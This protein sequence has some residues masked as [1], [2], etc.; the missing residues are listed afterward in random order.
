MANL[1]EV[2]RSKFSQVTLSAW[3]R[4]DFLES[5]QIVYTLTSNYDGSL[6]KTAELR[7]TFIKEFLWRT[8]NLY[9]VD[10][11]LPESAGV[12]I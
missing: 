3:E 12:H 10:K 11:D 1:A 8:G 4:Y 5:V 9:C 2:A 7:S 6:W